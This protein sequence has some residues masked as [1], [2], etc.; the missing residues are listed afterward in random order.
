MNNSKWK[1]HHFSARK[2]KEAKGIACCRFHRRKY[3]ILL[4]CKR[5][6]YAFFLFAYGQ[7]NSNNDEELIRILSGTTTEE[8]HDIYS[9]NFVQVWYRVFGTTRTPGYFL[10]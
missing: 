9:L 4:V 6:T 7:Y 10:A 1:G 3:E 2:S 8:K 5:Y